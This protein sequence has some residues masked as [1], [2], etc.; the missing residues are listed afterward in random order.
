MVARTS[1]DEV[2]V[3]CHVLVDRLIAPPPPRSQAAEYDEVL[4]MRITRYLIQVTKRGAGFPMFVYEVV[5]QVVWRRVRIGVEEFGS[6]IY[7]HTSIPRQQ[8]AMIWREAFHPFHHGREIQMLHGK[9]KR[10]GGV[11]C[12]CGFDA[13]CAAYVQQRGPDVAGWLVFSGC[14]EALG[15]SDAG[16]VV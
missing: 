8:L 2:I 6:D 16:V 11:V 5:E 3:P 14:E 1:V 12:I 13:D 10:R 15:M 4:T 7:L 9:C